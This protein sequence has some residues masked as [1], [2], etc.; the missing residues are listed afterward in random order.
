M[1]QIVDVCL[2]TGKPMSSRDYSSF[3]LFVQLNARTTEASRH[4][5]KK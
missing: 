3:L 2:E 1:R 5:M 4:V